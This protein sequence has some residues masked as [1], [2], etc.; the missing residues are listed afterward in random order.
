MPVSCWAASARFATLAGMAASH[1]S[2]A[3]E[4]E[5]RRLLGTWGRLWRRPG[6]EDAVSIEVSGRL[7]R[8]LGLAL[9][10]RGLIR[11][12]PAVATGPSGALAEILCHEA[13]HLVVHER[14]GRSVRPHGR[15]W[16]RLVESA[17]FTPRVRLDPARLGL[18]GWST[19]RPTLWR[20]RCPDCGAT[21][22]G[23]R[24]VRRWRCVRCVAAGR[25]G[26]LEVRRIARDE[27]GD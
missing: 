6:L 17:G 8:S 2:P 1:L 9:P 3:A 4:E 15:E 20:H 22:I 27:G 7:R 24:V 25:S 19:A 16:A 10:L 11:I 26:T 5:T 12:P 14:Y 23:R 18:V 13:A 21:R